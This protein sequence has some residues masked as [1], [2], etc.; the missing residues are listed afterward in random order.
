MPRGNLEAR[1][2]KYETYHGGSFMVR[3]RILMRYLNHQMPPY[4]FHFGIS[5]VGPK[6]RVIKCD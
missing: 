4:I 1:F 2:I 5:S 3:G 6:L